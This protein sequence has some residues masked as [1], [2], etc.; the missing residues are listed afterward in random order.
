MSGKKIGCLFV[1]VTDE[2]Y[3]NNYLEDNDEFFVPN[4]INSFKKWNPEVEVHYVNNDNLAEYCQILNLEEL[5]NH[6]SLIRLSL[7]K[8]LMNYYQYDKIMFL[9]IDTITCAPLNEFID[10][11]EDDA[12]FTL[13][14]PQ[15]VQ[16]KYWQTQITEFKEN[17]QTYI[18]VSFINGD[19][20]CYN[21]INTIELVIDLTLKYWTDHVDQG[22]MNFLYINQNQYNKKV[23]IVDYPYYK[24]PVV[25]NIRSKGVVGG[26][27]LIKG[28]VLNG[29][30]G[31]VIS[32]RYPM[33]DFYIKENKLYTKDN[34]HIK[35]F[36]FC[37]GLSLKTDEEEQSYSEAVYEIKNTWFNEETKKFLKDQCNCNY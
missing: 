5:Y 12:I 17:D 18:D 7:L 20:A 9:G 2:Y 25:Y 19:V 33:L 13:G 4:A 3:S 24:S 36:N 16:N 27:C 31:D 6:V 22:T 15:M 1:N 32:D 23:K 28:K 14:S 34:K 21:N 37:E 35:V 8:G 29:R 26:Y 11:D 30:N 10:N